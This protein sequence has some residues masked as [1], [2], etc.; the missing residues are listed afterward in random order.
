VFLFSFVTL[1]V[2]P[3]PALA[4]TRHYKFDVWVTCEMSLAKLLKL[5]KY[6]LFLFFFLLIRVSS[7]L[8][9]LTV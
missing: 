7:A 1:S 9:F 6:S 5:F 2:N 4:I 8:Y 3:E